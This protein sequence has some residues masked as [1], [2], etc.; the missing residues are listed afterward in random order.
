[1]YARRVAVRAFGLVRVLRR[2]AGARVR[3]LCRAVPATGTIGAAIVLDRAA[4][5]RGNDERD[6]CT[7]RAVGL[8]KRFRQGT[9]DVT[10]VRDVSLEVCAGELV[11]VMGP[12]GSGKSTLLHLLGG[13]DVPDAGSVVVAGHALAALSD[14][15]LTVFRRRSI[16]VVF[17]ASN[18]VPMLT[19]EENVALPLRLDGLAP[20]AV[21]DR[22]ERALAGVGL[23]H[24][25]AHLPDRLS[26]GELQ[27]V[28]IARALAIGPALV[29]A[30]EP[31]GSLD[32]RTADE[33][34]A[35]LARTV[36][37]HRCAIVMVTH[38]PRAAAHAD[39]V[40]R[41]VDGMLA[42]VAGASIVRGGAPCACGAS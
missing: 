18:L 32:S 22:V 34:L 38:D 4:L 13:L 40:V 36:R 41:V 30:D 6:G 9:E 15:A 42:P 14:D 31:T 27:R 25:R 12:S 5:A 29:L 23:L 35:L 24:R 16:G 1:V 10:A 2:R 3:S 21:S 28:A 37:D 39:R 11:A 20:A 26:G 7:V 17:Q 33:I 19:A 8:V